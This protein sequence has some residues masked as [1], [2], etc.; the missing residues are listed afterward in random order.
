MKALVLAIGDA[1]G[2]WATVISA[3]DTALQ[4]TDRLAD[5]VFQVGE[6]A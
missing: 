5:V 4:V 2:H 6:H 3:M 1:H